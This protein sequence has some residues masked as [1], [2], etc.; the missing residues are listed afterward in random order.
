MVPAAHNFG[1]K[2]ASGKE[3]EWLRND[4][5]VNFDVLRERKAKNDTSDA[6]RKALPK[7]KELRYLLV[8]EG[9]VRGL[10]ISPDGRFVSYRTFKPA[11]TKNTIIPDY[12]T[13]SGYTTDI[14]GRNK[15]GAEQGSSA[16][17][18]YDRD[19]DTVLTLP[20]ESIPGIR[21]LPDYLKDYP[22][23]F[24]KRKRTVHEELLLFMAFPGRPGAGILLSKFIQ[25]IIKTAG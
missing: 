25:M 16:F 14:F 15:V 11:A 5:L 21:D 6:Y 23:A 18:V 7:E 2:P 22:R 12:V 3:E 8:R 19:R 17:Y 13:E 10:N 24:D 4:Q 9:S 20:V 1:S